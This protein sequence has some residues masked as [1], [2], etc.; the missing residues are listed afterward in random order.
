[1]TTDGVY[2]RDVVHKTNVGYRACSTLKSMLS[3]IGWG[4]NANYL[5]EQLYQHSFFIAE[6]W[7]MRSAGRRKVKVLE[8]R[9]L[10]SLVGVSRMELRM[11]RCKESR[12][13]KGVGE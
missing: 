7:G 2:S 13:R 6:A 5:Y 8:M 10:R 12:N 11:R 4:L 9:C 1:M 3:N